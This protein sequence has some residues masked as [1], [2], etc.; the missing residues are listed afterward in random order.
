MVLSLLK[1][2]SQV[3]SSKKNRQAGQV[4][5]T[6]LL[7]MVVILA[8]AIS[9]SQRT[10]LEQDI[11][12]TQEKATRVFNAAEYGVEEA[13]YTIAE[14]DF[15]EDF[16]AAGYLQ[17]ISQL[18]FDDNLIVD[19]SIQKSSVFEMYVEQGSVV[20]I[21]L[22]ELEVD[23]ELEINW[24]YQ[25]DPV[26][27]DDDDPPALVISIYG[28][29]EGRHFGYD[30]CGGGGETREDNNFEDAS[31]SLV[32]DY[33]FAA[34]ITL[35]LTDELVRVTPLYNSSKIQIS[36]NEGAISDAQFEVNTRGIDPDAKIAQALNV[37]RSMPA[38]PG[39]MDYTL[40]SGGG[41]SK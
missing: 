34:T 13:L 20:E 18:T 41:L 4:G 37:L 6:T 33:L 19:T 25:E 9:L 31:A 27:D 10:V 32:D 26:C 12:L 11:A 21:P 30:P 28:D 35:E 23:D 15:D 40:V 8:I 36:A 7:I 29:N 16:S 39:F 5:I 2:S 3:C 1:K 24:W 22:D 14:E 38:A 17:N